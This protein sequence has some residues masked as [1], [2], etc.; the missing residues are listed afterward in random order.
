MKIEEIYHVTTLRTI[1]KYDINIENF[2]D[3]SELREY[4]NKNIKKLYQRKN[5]EYFRTYMRERY[6]LKKQQRSQVYDQ[7]NIKTI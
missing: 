5:A 2:K 3:I 6:R 4:I 1:K 7:N